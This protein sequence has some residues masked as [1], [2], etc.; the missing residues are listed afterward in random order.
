VTDTETAG[1]ASGGESETEGISGTDGNSMSGSTFDDP[2]GS[3]SESQ[4][5]N[6]GVPTTTT[7]DPTTT[8][9][10][11]QISTSNTS[12]TTED[13]TTEDPTTTTDTPVVCSEIEDPNE[14]DSN[15]ECAF[16]TSQIFE[17]DG[18]QVCFNE[19]VDVGCFDLA[20]DCNENYPTD[21]FLCEDG[22]NH[23]WVKFLGCVPFG[24][25]DECFPVPP[26]PPHPC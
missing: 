17:S 23:P 9:N 5:D 11:T 19:V 8:T 10:D 22:E 7:D 1:T 14:C 21:E 16:V 26:A 12:T 2:G 15:D 4:G 6:T 25:H 13:P 20:M 3:E 18:A 24:Y